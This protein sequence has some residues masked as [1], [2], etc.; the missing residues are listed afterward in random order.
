MPFTIREAVLARLDVYEEGYDLCQVLVT[1]ESGTTQEAKA[2]VARP[3]C[4]TDEGVP[5][6]QSTWK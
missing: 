4:T 5:T 3:E 6:S 2:D 1:L